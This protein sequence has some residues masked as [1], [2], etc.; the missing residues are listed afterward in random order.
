MHRRRPCSRKTP[1]IESHADVIELIEIAFEVGFDEPWISYH[2]DGLA[3]NRLVM[4][5][6]GNDVA[7]LV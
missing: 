2:G 1:I 4:G 5:A 3:G 6:E 7:T